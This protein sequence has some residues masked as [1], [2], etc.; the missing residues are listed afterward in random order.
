MPKSACLPKYAS[1]VAGARLAL[2]EL[3]IDEENG[4]KYVQW[5]LGSYINDI[6]T[7]KNTSRG[8]KVVVIWQINLQKYGF[9]EQH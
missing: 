4:L 6:K 3:H 9:F 5:S 8:K 7:F 1:P 2:L